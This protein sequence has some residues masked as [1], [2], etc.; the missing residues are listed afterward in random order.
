MVP[1]TLSTP[2]RIGNT[3]WVSWCTDQSSDECSMISCRRSY[4]SLRITQ[5]D[6]RCLSLMKEMTSLGEFS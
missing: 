4:L 6:P 1:L 3:V 5:E 2:R